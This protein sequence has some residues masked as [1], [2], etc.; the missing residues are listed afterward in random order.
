MK[1][2]VIR[3]VPMAMQRD[4]WWL[5]NAEPA[6][7]A[8]KHAG[9][10][11]WMRPLLLVALIALADFLLWDVAAGLSLAVFAIAL[12]GAAALV[13]DPTLNKR[14]LSMIGMGTLLC[15]LPIV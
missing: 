8:I 1:S 15:V 5:S 14:K 2:Y 7:K 3:G 9:E 4:G 6:G 10:T 11:V 12:V 13:I